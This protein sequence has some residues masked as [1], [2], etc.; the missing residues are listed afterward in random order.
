MQPFTYGNLALKTPNDSL[1]ARIA[2]GESV[3]ASRPRPSDD[4][5]RD[6]DGTPK[7]CRT[8]L[9]DDESTSRTAAAEKRLRRVVAGNGRDVGQL[10]PKLVRLL[11][12]PVSSASPRPVNDENLTPDA[13]SLPASTVTAPFRL[14]RS[15]TPTFVPPPPPARFGM[16]NLAQS[17]STQ[18]PA[19]SHCFNEH[20]DGRASC[21]PSATRRIPGPAGDIAAG[22]LVLEDESS[23][24]DTSSI[25]P[26]VKM[27]SASGRRRWHVSGG[28][29]VFCSGAWLAMC[30]AFD[31]PPV[32]A[33]DPKRE[34][35]LARYNVGSVMLGGLGDVRKVPFLAVVVLK[36]RFLVEGVVADVAD[37]TG[38]TEAEIHE[39]VVRCNSRDIVEGAVLVLRHVTVFRPW[40]AVAA[41]HSLIVT[42]SNIERVFSPDEPVPA[43]FKLSGALEGIRSRLGTEASLSR[44]DVEGA[45]AH[46]FVPAGAVSN[47]SDNEEF[48]PCSSLP[49][50]IPVPSRERRL[51]DVDVIDEALEA[52]LA[53]YDHVARRAPAQPAAAVRS[54]HDLSWLDDDDR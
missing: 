49:S 5:R 21:P 23:A 16:G 29:L 18:P 52:A 17:S 26:P 20:N 7:L 14:P 37:P 28:D 4:Q 1:G 36:L 48:P 35:L 27:A 39:E 51:D 54:H 13:P 43:Q 10:E 50:S 45:S 33:D 9:A 34:S 44:L 8:R 22:L 15:I 30:A 40:L 42:E 38:E 41:T 32:L 31:Q 25:R 46:V 12:S 2:R 19:T 24:D 53:R 3:T 47:N 6:S 11:R